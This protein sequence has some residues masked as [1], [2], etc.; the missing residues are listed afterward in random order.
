MDADGGEGGRG[1]EGGARGCGGG[2]IGTTTNYVLRR[3][4]SVHYGVLLLHSMYSVLLHL[5]LHSGVDLLNT[6]LLAAV[7]GSKGGK[8]S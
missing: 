7:I 3:D 6:P 5:E 4:P 2:Q 1:R 8:S